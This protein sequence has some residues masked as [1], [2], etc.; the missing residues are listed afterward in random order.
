MGSIRNN[1]RLSGWVHYGKTPAEVADLIRELPESIQPWIGRI[2]WWDRFSFGTNTPEFRQ[3]IETA[4]TD[5]PDPRDIAAGLIQLGYRESDAM[6]RACGGDNQEK[7]LRA[8]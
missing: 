2:I 4:S 6:I 5:D 3:W 7:R 1:P 8:L